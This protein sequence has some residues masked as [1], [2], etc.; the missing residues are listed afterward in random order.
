MSLRKLY[1]NY[2]QYS[3]RMLILAADI[4]E[5]SSNALHICVNQM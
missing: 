3:I 2:I 4:F 5:S 1:V